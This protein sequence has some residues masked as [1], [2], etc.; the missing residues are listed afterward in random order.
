M[1]IKRL[2]PTACLM[3]AAIANDADLSICGPWYEKLAP[4]PS[5][6]RSAWECSPDAPRR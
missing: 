3:L 2:Y 5:F 6:P 4:G 1:P